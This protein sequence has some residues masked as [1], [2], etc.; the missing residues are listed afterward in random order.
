MM[1]L[2]LASINTFSLIFQ[3]LNKKKIVVKQL[4]EK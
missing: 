2:A 3:Q 1:L 4:V